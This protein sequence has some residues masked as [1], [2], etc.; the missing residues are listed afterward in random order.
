M[1]PPY[2]KQFGVNQLRSVHPDFD[3]FGTSAMKKTSE[4]KINI[5]RPYGGTGFIY[6]KRF[7]KCLKPILSYSHERVTVMEL[8]TES[9]KIILINTYFPYFNSRDLST[10]LSMYRD[11]VGFIDNI[12]SQNPDCKFLLL[13]DLNCNIYDV[14]HCYT[15]LIRGLME[16]HHLIS[17]FDLLPTF[18]VNSAFTRFDNKTNSRTLIDGILM[19]SELRDVVSIIR[20]SNYGNNVSDH[21]PVELTLRASVSVFEPR[22]HKSKPFINWGK[23][24]QNDLELFEQKLTQGLND[25]IIPSHGV[26]HGSYVCL[27]DSHKLLI[28]NYYDNIITAIINAESVLPKTNP[29]IHRS[30]W[31][32]E[33]SELKRVSLECTNFWKDSGKPLSGPIFQC[34]KNCQNRYKIALRREKNLDKKEQSDAMYTDLLNRDHISFWK[35]WNSLNRVSN[36]LVSQIGGETHE[37]GVAEVFA[38]YFEFVYGGSDSPKHEDLKMEF[39]ES[40]SN[41]FSS[42]INDDLMS[43][44]LTWSD[45]VDLASKIK[46]GKATAGFIKPQHFLHG[47]PRLLQHFQILFNSML[48]HGFVPTDFPGGY[49]FSYH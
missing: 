29:S 46:V 35:S 40:F 17:A 38:T 39:N 47:G 37:K 48:Q 12:M 41:Y 5:G 44:Y 22:K 23:L 4:S 26:F 42:H 19:S 49:D 33:L 8:N 2:K 7:S 28:K 11:T 43:T 15:K 24:S 34:K 16:K 18:D 9:D 21:L 6:S 13:A 27:N 10:Y 14:S 25:I 30:F 32:E 36:S 1:R 31:T 3:G 45:M 20:I